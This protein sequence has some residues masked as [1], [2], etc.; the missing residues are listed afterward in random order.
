MPRAPLPPEL[1]GF[2]AKPRPAV[3]ATIRPDG[4]PTTAASWYDWVDERVVLS[5][6]ARGAR[7]R[8]IRRDP[9]IAL[10]VLGD[11]WHTQVSLVGRAVEIREDSDYADVN[12]LSVRYLGEPYSR[13]DHPIVTV[14]VEVD[15]WHTWG[16]PASAG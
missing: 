4:S 9:R 8:N 16:D 2:L 7:I 14:L 5:M 12:A 3:V 11:D 10:T 1:E 13:R 6:D 15:R